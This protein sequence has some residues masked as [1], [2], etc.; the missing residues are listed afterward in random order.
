MFGHNQ[1]QEQD[2]IPAVGTVVESRPHHRD[3]LY[4]VDYRSA[5]GAAMRAT[6]HALPDRNVRLD[7]GTRIGIV[8]E[9]TS[10]EARC[11]PNQPPGGA[12][13]PESVNQP[14]Q[15]AATSAAPVAPA[16]PLPPVT[17]MPPV[18]AV[19]PMAPAAPAAGTPPP[20]APPQV[21]F[22]TP[23]ASV[24]EPSAGAYDPVAPA[25]SFS[26]PA[27]V[28]S[29]NGG[30]SSSS[31]SFGGFGETKSDRIARLEDARDRGQLTP[32]QFATQRQQILDEI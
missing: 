32:E 26:S 29:F 20:L 23:A 7:A 27:S 11:D 16:A 12:F 13:V 24:G 14:G 30:S 18:A 8:V 1:E 15:N 9:A 2:W 19:P 10:H 21:T 3:W 22:S 28:E 5:A 31:G 17:P 6:V 25:T 4:V